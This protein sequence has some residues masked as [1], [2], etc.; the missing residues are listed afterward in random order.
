MKQR[1]APKIPLAVLLLFTV[2]GSTL[3]FLP[4][5]VFAKN[6]SCGDTITANTTLTANIGP[7][8]GNGLT[9]GA[10][11]IVL[12]CAGYTID[13]TGSNF[14][15]VG[16]S[17]IGRTG[18][19]VENCNVMGFQYGFQLTVSSSNNTLIGNTADSNEIGF[20]LSSS[21]R[22]TLTANTANGEGD[23]FAL[24]G[25]S[26][27]TLTANT[28][29]S[30]DYGFYLGSSSN[31]NALVG[32]TA[33][34][35]YGDGFAVL[36]SSNDTLT[37]NISNGG[38]DHD[39]FLGGASHNTLT[40]NTAIYSD[41]GFYLYF[42]SSNTLASNVANNVHYDGFFLYGSFTNALTS[43][44]ADSNGGYGFDLASSSSN[45]LTSNTADSNLY[46]GFYLW[47]SSSNTL[48]SDTADSNLYDGFYLWNSSSNTLTSNT[49]DSNTQYGDVDLSSGSGTEATA[50]FY[51]GDFCSGNGLGGSSP[52]GLCLPLV[53]LS[54]SPAPV[55]VGSVTTCKATV[56]AT[57]PTG[58]VA[59]SSSSPGKFYGASCKLSRHRTYI[60]CSVKFAPTAA[61][62]TVILTANYG[63]DTKNF[64][65]TGT[66]NL[67]VL[68]KATTT[69]VSC[70]PKPVVIGSSKATTCKAMVKGYVPT[71]IVTWTQSGTGSVFF[72]PTTCTLKKYGPTLTRGTCSVRMAGM[73]AGTVTLQ[74]TYSGDPNNLGSYKTATLTIK[75]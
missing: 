31:N 10:S 74:A 37:S 63:G 58:S 15:N 13:S 19:T 41:Y 52:S 30:D 39:F 69:K 65:F 6:P 36:D 56:K 44:T 14:T 26:H 24:D 71:G 7:C 25:A 53:L 49:A 3:A 61:A 45:T 73:T 57:A 1:S 66:Y 27:N 43:N 68:K 47:N 17:L 64:Q 72:Y 42:S 21:S 22:N 28:A 38:S 50:N 46:F 16:I 48:T 9:I 8:S 5:P 29:D 34:N 4:P 33:H 18:V 23:G 62:S 51:T 70:S 35:S 20:A 11:N 2:L 54:C 60:T 75:P 67:T 59:W 12:N 32:N 55:V 40:A